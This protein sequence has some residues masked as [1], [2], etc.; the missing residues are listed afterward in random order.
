MPGEPITDLSDLVNRLTGGNDGNPENLAFFM[1]MRAGATNLVFAAGRLTSLWTA[2]KSPGGQ[3][4]YPTTAAVCNNTTNG[5]LGH[6][7]ASGSRKKYVVGGSVMAGFGCGLFVYDRLVH[8]GGLVGNVNT[9]QTT[10][11]PTPDLTRY[12]DGIDNG[13][14]LEIHTLIGTTNVNATVKYINQDDDEVSSK[15]TSFG[16][17]G[18]REIDRV[19]PVPLRDG[20]TGVKKIVSVTL[21][22]TTGIEGAFG[23]FIGHRL[24]ECGS[25]A[26]N[27]QIFDFITGRPSMPEI[28]A[29]EC[30]SFMMMAQGATTASNVFG[31]IN[32][33]QK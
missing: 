2:N 15:L 16:G 28:T 24:F 17:T 4:A 25:T 6:V 19:V 3:G 26:G 1:D 32:T 5:G 10:N 29:D 23:V 21:S 31:F 27:A 33:V 18:L 22:A 7:P 12:T 9:E 13:I 8:A 20:D 30:I 14:F 11:L